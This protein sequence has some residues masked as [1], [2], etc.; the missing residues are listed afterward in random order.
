VAGWVRVRC[1]P[2]GVRVRGRWGGRGGAGGPP[3]MLTAPRIILT[4]AGPFFFA[5]GMDL[6]ELRE[7]PESP[8]K[9]ATV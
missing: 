6:A 2:D 5:Q 8:R 1:W 3:M 7:S 4:A 9:N